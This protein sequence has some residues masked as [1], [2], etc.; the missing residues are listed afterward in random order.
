MQANH[1]LVRTFYEDAH[2]IA[3]D[4][5]PMIQ[6]PPFETTLPLYLP[7]CDARFHKKKTLR[8]YA[9]DTCDNIVSYSS[10]TRCN[11]SRALGE[12]QGSY[13][14]NSWQDS[15]PG[16]LLERAYESRL[17]DCTW[18]CTQFCGAPPTGVKDRT[19]RTQK[20]QRQQQENQ[21][22]SSRSW[23]ASGAGSSQGW[24]GS[25]AGSSRGW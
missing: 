4:K 3:P 10:W 19:T 25:G 22:W 21:A 2:R 9:C 11:S 5:T 14:D 20:W 15:I 18:S 1:E 17:I 13:V 7:E 12:F 8:V 6:N 16:E 24:Y 23:Y